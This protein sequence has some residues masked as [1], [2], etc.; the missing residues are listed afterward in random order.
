MILFVNFLGDKSGKKTV[1]YRVPTQYWKSIEFQ[2]RFSRPWKSIEI[3]QN[4]H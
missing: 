3:G 4:M 1:S 2:N